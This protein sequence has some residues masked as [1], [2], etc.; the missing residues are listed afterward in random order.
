MLFRSAFVVVFQSG[1]E[2]VQAEERK[3]AAEATKTKG[4]GLSKFKKISQKVIT[5]LQRFP[6]NHDILM[7]ASHC[8]NIDSKLL[9]VL[10]GANKKSPRSSD[11][12]GLKV[13]DQVEC[14]YGVGKIVKVVGEG[15]TMMYVIKVSNYT[16]PDGKEPTLFMKAEMCEKYV[17][18]GLR[19]TTLKN[20]ITAIVFN[21][22]R[23]GLFDVHKLVISSLVVLK[24]QEDDG[25]LDP[26][27]VNEILMS[28]IDPDAAEFPAE[29]LPWLPANLW[30]KISALEKNLGPT[31]PVFAGLTASITSEEIGR[32]HV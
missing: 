25:Q 17:D 20:S 6:W 30:P 31:N 4:W 11:K 28:P 3:K 23:R 15:P 19:C 1:I 10:F 14:D 29:E 7:D 32:A 27:Y 22:I 24:L 18:Y 16:L 2:A 21:Y 8:D 13:N 9:S 26:A 12:D 5:G